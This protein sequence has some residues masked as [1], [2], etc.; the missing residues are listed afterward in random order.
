M[1]ERDDELKGWWLMVGDER[2]YDEITDYTPC[3]C[4][5]C[6]N[7]IK[8]LKRERSAK[9]GCGVKSS[10]VMFFRIKDKQ[11]KYIYVAHSYN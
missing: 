1:L 11:R 3:T 5:Y 8:L 9:M 2:K 7:E 10:K 4:M 6:N